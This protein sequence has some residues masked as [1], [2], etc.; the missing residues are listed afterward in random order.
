MLAEDTVKKYVSR[1][2]A[3]TGCASRTQLAL[4]VQS[5]GPPAT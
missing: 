1:I 3:A 2:L 5:F 4:E